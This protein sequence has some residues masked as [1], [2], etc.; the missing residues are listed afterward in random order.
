MNTL[1]WR[2]TVYNSEA[3]QQFEISKAYVKLDVNWGRVPV[4][5]LADTSRSHREVKFASQFGKGPLSWLFAM[6]KSCSVGASAAREDG[7]V[8]SKR[9]SFNNSSE[10]LDKLPNEDGRVPLRSLSLNQSALHIKN[11]L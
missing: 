3:S 1:E 10:R 7:S 5:K 2:G 6:L 4:N 9:L 11:T 8:P